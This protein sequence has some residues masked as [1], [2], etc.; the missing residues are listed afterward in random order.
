M[1]Q[2]QTIYLQYQ[3]LKEWKFIE[4]YN[5]PTHTILMADVIMYTL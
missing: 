3:Q 5:A 1:V 2:I 4:S